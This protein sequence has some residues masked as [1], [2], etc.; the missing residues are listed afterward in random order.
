MSNPLCGS[1]AN[2]KQETPQDM[3]PSHVEK[4]QSSQMKNF[5]W[6]YQQVL[7]Q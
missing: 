4:R 1:A 5:I 6:E 2:I 7:M 3:F